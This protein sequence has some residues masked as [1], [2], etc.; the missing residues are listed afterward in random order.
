MLFMQVT[1]QT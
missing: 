1:F